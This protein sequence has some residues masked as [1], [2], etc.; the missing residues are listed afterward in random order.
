LTSETDIR[1]YFLNTHRVNLSS[2]V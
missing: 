1:Q 2:A